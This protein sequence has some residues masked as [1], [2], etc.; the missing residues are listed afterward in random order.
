MCEYTSTTI[1]TEDVNM[2]KHIYDKNNGLW[3]ELRGDYY[4]PWVYEGA[5]AFFVSLQ[6]VC[7]LGHYY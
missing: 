3:Y 2:E 4:Y 7:L 5:V 6:P 1:I